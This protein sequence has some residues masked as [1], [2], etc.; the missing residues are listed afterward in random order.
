MA[1][2]ETKVP[3][4][5]EQ[6]ESYAKKTRAQKILKKHEQLKSAKAFWIPTWEFVGMYVL[7][8]K[9]DIGNHVQEGTG[10]VTGQIFDST[11]TRANQQMA[12][13]IIGAI[14][15]NGPKTFK[16]E[17]P[18]DMEMAEACKA[19]NKNYYNKAT[20]RVQSAMNDNRAGLITSLDEYMLDQ[21]SFGTSGI[22]EEEN[23][24]P[25]EYQKPFTFYAV[26]CK[27][28]CIM[29]GKDGFVDTVYIEKHLTVKQMI[30]EFGEACSK[31]VKDMWKNDRPNEKVKVLHAIEPRIPGTTA[32]FGN[33]GLPIGS[34]H[35]EIDSQK[36]LKES[37]YSEM[38]CFITRFWKANGEIYGRSPGTESM[39]DIIGANIMGEAFALAQ[40][41]MLDPPGILSHDGS[42]GGGIVDRS[43]GGLTIRNVQGRLNEANHK[44]WEQLVTIGDMTPT[45]EYIEMLQV[46]IKEA[47]FIDRLTDFNNDT[48]MT[49]G[50]ANM[51][52][53]M[54]G[55]S[56][57]TTYARQIS[58]LFDKLVQRAFH[59]MLG[60]G[61]LGVVKDS[62]QYNDLMLAGEDPWVIPDDIAARMLANKHSY[63]VTFISP[64]VRAM[65]SE[66]LNGIINMLS[67][68]E[69]IAPVYPQILDTIDWDALVYKLQEL[70]G[71]P[72]EVLNSL[73]RIQEIRNNRDQMQL[74]MAK[75]QQAEQQ[76]LTAKHASQAAAETTKAGLPPFSILQGL[77]Q[78]S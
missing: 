14:W 62:D 8:R 34:I 69:K 26:D 48:R 64:A 27:K 65:R 16:L 39:P 76:S 31:K 67:F 3:P 75:A 37:G 19:E 77:Q 51:R 9:Q 74:Q 55:Q 50:E 44:V 40:E 78:A 38:P 42:I 1:A 22:F 68:I 45:K 17:P 12:S 15:P 35:I 66:E 71:S 11:A 5:T 53:Q 6:S 61:L 49:L 57:N 20:K 33:K 23:F 2:L 60:K 41:V 70:T 52:D 58:E 56:L 10:S 28:A 21:G 47:F 32:M 59:I 63:K 29:E 4:E 36:I 46:N 24:G 73:E 7:P 43:A 72:D 13:A 25:D 30:E 18:D 54:R